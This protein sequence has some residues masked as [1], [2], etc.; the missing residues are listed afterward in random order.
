MRVLI[1]LF[2]QLAFVILTFVTGILGGAPLLLLFSVADKY[3]IFLLQLITI[4]ILCYFK[5]FAPA[6]LI[7]SLWLMMQIYVLTYKRSF[8]GRT[9]LAAGIGSAVFI[10]LLIL[11]IKSSVDI[12][13]LNYLTNTV[14][15][16]IKETQVVMGSVELD[17]QKIVYQLP[18]IVICLFGINM[19]LAAVFDK[20]SKISIL[21]RRVDKDLK[22]YRTP[23]PFIWVVIL[24]LLF[25]FLQVP[26]TGLQEVALNTLNVSLLLYFFQGLSVLSFIMD[27]LK[28]NLFFRMIVNFLF[29]IQIL[30]P[31][32]LGIL[33]F[34][35]NFRAKIS[36]KS[37]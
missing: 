3:L 25:S 23:E 22:N 33:D 13:L 34:W 7:F 11:G 30:L 15:R 28:F 35:L 27:Q 26:V 19:W 18:S 9:F 31:I 29:I 4:T 8:F 21:G 32:C 20:R 10:I 37:V 5:L 36:K 6:L 17:V 14:E 12:D 24:S 2:L 1:A 16:Y